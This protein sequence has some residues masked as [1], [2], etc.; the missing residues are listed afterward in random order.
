MRGNDPHY[1]VEIR[2]DDDAPN[3][4]EEWDNLGH[5]VYSK[6]SRY[7]LGDEAVDPDAPPTPDPLADC[8]LLLRQTLAKVVPYDLATRHVIAMFGDQSGA[9]REDIL[10]ALLT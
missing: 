5:I 8:A 9:D 10:R 2:Q 4:R 6:F 7:V 1:Y 3:P